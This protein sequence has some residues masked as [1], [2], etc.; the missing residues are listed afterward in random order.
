[1]QATWIEKR[2]NFIDISGEKRVKKR[3]ENVLPR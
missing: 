2:R 3:K 1:M